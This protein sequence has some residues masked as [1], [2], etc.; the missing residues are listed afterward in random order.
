MMVLSQLGIRFEYKEWDPTTNSYGNTYTY[1]TTDLN[2]L[3]TKISSFGN[4]D[5]PDS[6]DLFS[7]RPTLYKYWDR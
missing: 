2:S 1:S 6:L 3:I 7:H 4:A 5:P